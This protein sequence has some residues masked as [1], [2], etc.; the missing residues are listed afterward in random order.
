[1]HVCLCVCLRRE[2]IRIRCSTIAANSFLFATLSLAR[3]IY[4]YVHIVIVPSMS[5]KAATV[6]DVN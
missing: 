4:Q 1:M 6:A 3:L 5:A 2:F